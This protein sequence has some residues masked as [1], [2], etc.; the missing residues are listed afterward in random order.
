LE[1]LFT[2]HQE[3]GMSYPG[4]HTID[5]IIAVC[6]I[7]SII[8]IGIYL[9]K[10]NKSTKDFM[11]AGK[12]MGWLAVGLSLMATLTSAVGYMA[13]PTGIIK[14]GI[15]N[16]WMAMA[17]PLSFPLVVWVFMPFY[18]KLNCYTAY[19]YLERRFNVSVRALASG[20]FILWR[21]TWMA[22][23]IY[24]PSMVLNV[25]TNGKIPILLSALVLGFMTTVNSS[26][27]GIR[28][29]MWAD[30]VHSFVMFLSMI[31]GVVV[32]VLAV[33]GG[34]SEIWSSLAAAGKTSMIA[35]IPGF[36]DANL[37]GKMKFY[38]YTDITVLALIVT[39]TVQKMGNY[40]VDQAMVQRYLT[41]KSL[42][43]SREG[44]YTN[45]VAYLFYILCVSAIGAGLFVVT[46]H[47]AFPATLKVDQIF[48]YFIANMMPIGI[49]GLMIAAIYAASMSS[50]DS[51]LNS[52]ITAILNDFYSRF[53]LKK[54]NLDDSDIQDSEKLRRL[55]IARFSTLVLGALITFFSLYVGKMGDIFVYSQ[56]LINMFTGPLFGVFFLGMF[57]KRVT[58]P[59]ALIGGF[60]GFALGSLSVFAK[61]IHIKSLMV[62]VLWPATIAFVMTL[63]LGYLLSFVIGKRNPD[64][65][66]WTWR[67]VMKSQ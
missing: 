31:T 30:V 6:Y 47:Y 22:A 32:I 1:Q 29:I 60:I 57:T 59:A 4:L 28:A 38:L 9:F 40:C 10:K 23:V 54:Y 26:L 27:G 17:I 50:L 61:F 16:V 45:C 11:L 25:V 33:P 39:Y 2:K 34:V 66:Q 51:G 15:I 44:F 3:E 19:E 12:N 65:S 24:V 63:I 46:K 21:L 53:K 35:N 5:I 36:A 48:P 55:R 7:S 52:C 14:Y 58:A 18:H 56:K 41:A 49:T 20:I 8:S 37:F 42:K 43:K 64:A 13:F 62:G 67:G